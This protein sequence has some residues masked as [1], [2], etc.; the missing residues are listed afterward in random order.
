M[1]NIE[2]FSFVMECNL[3]GEQI[4]IWTDSEEMYQACVSV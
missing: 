2:K 1:A 3:R 4:A